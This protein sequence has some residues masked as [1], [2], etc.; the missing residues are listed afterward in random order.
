[1][2]E[3]A[4]LLELMEE[5]SSAV[6]LVNSRGVKF[7]EEEI[8]EMDS[9]LLPELRSLQVLPCVLSSYPVLLLFTFEVSIYTIKYVFIKVCILLQILRAGGMEACCEEVLDHFKSVM[10]TYVSSLQGGNVSVPMQ[11]SSSDTLV[12]SIDG[13]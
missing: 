12:F 13:F 5:S 10:V 11:T 3:Y 9:E 1:M 6:G 7:L 8:S 2:T 4:A